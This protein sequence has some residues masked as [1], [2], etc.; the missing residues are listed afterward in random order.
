[1]TKQYGN[2]TRSQNNNFLR[3][4]LYLVLSSSSIAFGECEQAV[5]RLESSEGTVTV[6]QGGNWQPL[7]IGACVPTGVRVQVSTG[8]AVF[9]LANETLLRASGTT[10]L[11]F[12][13]PEEKSW[14]HLFDGVL[15]F[16]T[17][18]PHAFD[19][20]TDYVNA[21]VKGTEF[22][23]A[24][25]RTEQYGEVV[26]LEGDVLASNENGQQSVRGGAAVIARNGQAP[27]ILTVPALRDAVQWTLYYPPLPSTKQPGFQ[28]ALERLH[29]GDIVG[30]LAQL[31]K[32][33]VSDRDADYHALVAA[34]DLQR[35][36]TAQARIALD[37][38][39]ALQPAHPQALALSA[40]SAV[41]VGDTNRASTLLKQAQAQ[42]PRD[43]SVLIARS[44]LEQAQ[45]QLADALVSAQQAAEIDSNAALIQARVAELALMNGDTKQAARAADNAIKLQPDLA[46][47]HAINGFIRLQQ[48]EFDAAAASFKRAAELD[49]TDPLPRLGLG[50]INIRHNHVREGREQLALAVALDPGQ[51]LL[52]SYLGK[53]YQEEGRERLAGDQ[54]ALAKTFDS[55]DPTP[56]F[57]SALLAREQ[58][59]PFDAL[60][61]LNHSIALNGNRAVYRSRLQLD[62]DEAA[63]TA[64]QAEIYRELGFDDLAQ[65]TAARAVSAAPSEYGGHRQ[66]AESYAD[67][68]QYDAARASEVL[69]AQLLQPLSATPLLPLLGETNLLATE[70][71]G[72]SALGFREYNQMF[73]REKPWLSV[74]GLGGSNHTGADEITLSGIYDRFSYALNQYHYETL[75]Y[76]DNNDVS[77]DVLS[78]YTK[79]QATE[80]LSFL[81]QVGQR[82]ENRGNLDETLLQDQPLSLLQTK[83]RINSV[84]LGSHLTISPQVELLTALSHQE[85]KFHQLAH[86]SVLD[87]PVDSIFKQKPRTSNAEIQGQFSN[88]P[89]HLIIGADWAKMYG[90]TVQSNET[91]DPIVQL[92]LGDP[93]ITETTDY[94]RTGYGYWTIAPTKPL[95]LTFGIAYAEYDAETFTKQLSG[96][97]PKFAAVYQLNPQLI[98]RT[99]YL[100]SLKRPLAIEQTLEPTEVGGFNQFTD[101]AE[102][103][104]SDQY[105]VGFDFDIGHGHRLGG[106]AFIRKL[107]IPIIDP[108]SGLIQSNAEQKQML[109]FWNWSTNPWAISLKY[110]YEKSEYTDTDTVALFGAATPMITQSIPMRV[111]WQ[112]QNG[113]T[114][115]AIATYFNQKAEFDDGLT[116]A[117]DN[118][119]LLDAMVSY[120][121][122]NHHLEVELRCNNLFD[123][124]FRY[125]NTNLYDPTPRISPYIPE[126][127][128]LIGLKLS[129]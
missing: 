57:Y 90:K 127:T 40:V 65:R 69:Q 126:R 58:N 32:L 113:L 79:F 14:I 25:N 3:W 10:L 112:S 95:E 89:G 117:D 17:R 73:V 45:F 97:Y 29:R 78:A 74:S 56:W 108:T 7:A 100:Q 86:I 63:R 115:S 68:P 120:P 72:P 48:L 51:S 98:L 22:I 88:V 116:K 6:E 43:T 75:G 61:D 20:Q 111:Q 101:E 38:A 55:A 2:S 77:Y 8:R 104:E 62:A 109:V 124:S 92:I 96:W 85:A 30:A 128:F 67:D 50:L 18:T 110:I 1:M 103:I 93:L 66:L 107:E 24:A 35:G 52:R 23:L 5:G 106:D 46:R 4:W 16:I 27:Q 26:M 44:Y 37:R 13:A 47:A 71:A 99:S 28:P 129:Y 83:N 31:E 54:Y 59:R 15:H 53:A 42:A 70:G 91:T 21:G 125:Q 84:L 39:L 80:A 19:V 87:S 60:D 49:A 94:Y 105:A 118:F 33:P 81:L 76:R 121:F 114:I 11:R 82:E 119:T 64:S 41:A 12:S 34:I 123:K 9:R 122:F 36:E 102:G